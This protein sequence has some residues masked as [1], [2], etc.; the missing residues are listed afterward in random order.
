MIIARKEMASGLEMIL[1]QMTALGRWQVRSQILWLSTHSRAFL[2]HQQF[3]ASQRKEAGRAD[4]L[5]RDWVASDVF[6][7]LTD[8][9]LI[10][11]VR[12]S[13]NLV[14]YFRRENDSSAWI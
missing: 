4:K 12:F 3:F 9:R 2:P 10:I 14:L 5:K 11:S 8:R 13:F 6:Q 7:L 1:L